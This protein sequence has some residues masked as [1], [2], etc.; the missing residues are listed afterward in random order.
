MKWLN[1]IWSRP[2][3]VGATVALSVAGLMGGE[4][5][6]W[7]V[8]LSLCAFLVVHSVVDGVQERSIRGR[9][10]RK[11]QDIHLRISHLVSDLADLTA[12]GFDLWVVDLYLPRSSWTWSFHR[13]F[14]KRLVRELSVSLADVSSAPVTLK[15]GDELFGASFTSVRR[16]LWWDDD[17]GTRTADNWWHCLDDADNTR[18]RQRFGV[19]CVSPVVDGL[20]RNCLGLLVV[21]TNTDVETATKGLG[22]LVQPK[23]WRCLARA[24]QG[25]HGQ[26]T[27]P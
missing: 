27:R 8:I 23:G 16:A 18:L 12:G 5:R 15:L 3:F 26:I 25:V 2:V 22:A 14:Y 9:L 19:V 6:P 7:A 20:G 24:C 17:L 21:H 13:P 11:Y 1:L 4:E 10:G